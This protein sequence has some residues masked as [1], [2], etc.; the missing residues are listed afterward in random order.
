MR[1]QDLTSYLNFLLVYFMPWDQSV[2]GKVAGA[3]E[4]NAHVAMA[5]KK[6]IHNLLPLT[7]VLSYALVRFRNFVE[8]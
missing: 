5:P 2:R 4:P 1:G 6:F 3:L 8:K 7:G